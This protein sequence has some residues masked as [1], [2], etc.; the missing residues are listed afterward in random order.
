MSSN[1][2]VVD[3]TVEDVWSILADGWLYPL[4]VVGA[5]RMREVDEGWPAP[6]TQLHHSVGSWPV[7]LDDATEV[8][9][10]EPPHM[11]R[12]AARAWPSGAAE[13]TFTLE[14]LGDRTRIVLEE[15]A[16]SGPGALLPSPA[17]QPLLH[18]RNSETLTRLALLA[19][20]R[21]AG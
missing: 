13:V 19:E 15:D 18:W 21:A 5:S 20:N 3:A 4:F 17:R 14:A 16:V 9:S 2:T 7:L 1:E 6:G 12:L 8:L 11:I 10:C